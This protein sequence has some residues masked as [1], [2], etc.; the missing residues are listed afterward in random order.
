MTATTITTHTN[1]PA[2]WRPGLLAALGAAAATTVVAVIGHAAG[3]NF[4]APEGTSIPVLGF[5]QLTVIF[6][7]VGVVLAAALRRWA[8]RARRTFITATV[9]LTALSLVPDATFGFDAVAAAVLM[10]AHL[11]AAAIV[12][13]VVARCLP[14]Y[15]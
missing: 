9:V 13:P 6:A 14:T 1:R 3:V 10:S 15:R 8:R 11:L 5:T 4:A 7:V 2:L 12:I